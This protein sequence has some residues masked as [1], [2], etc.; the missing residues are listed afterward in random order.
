VAG[1]GVH[2]D[3]VAHLSVSGSLAV[4]TLTPEVAPGETRSWTAL[5]MGDVVVAG[6][7][8]LG[9]DGLTAQITVQSLNVNLASTGIARLDWTSAFD[10]DGDSVKDVLNPGADLPVAQDLSIDFGAD[11]ELLIAGTLS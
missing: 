5:K 9:L 10:L 4:A 3:G 6:N 8:N 1:I 2:V 11:L 7:V